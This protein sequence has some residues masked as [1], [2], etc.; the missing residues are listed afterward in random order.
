[1]SYDGAISNWL[2]ARAPDGSAVA[3][4]E[5]LNL[6]AIKVQDLRYGENPHQQAALYRDEHPAA[7]TIA[8]YR[9]LQGKELAYNNLADGDAAWECVKT[10]ADAGNAAGCVIVKHANPCGAAVADTP[11]A[12]YGRAFATDPVSAFGGIIAFNR[13]VDGP[14]LDAVAA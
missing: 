13:P 4:P 11:L 5:R 12:A 9:Q 6:Q 14:T 10:L 3:F 1:A 7:G 8:T 2:T